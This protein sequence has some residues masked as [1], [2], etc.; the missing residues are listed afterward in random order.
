M[1]TTTPADIRAMFERKQALLKFRYA[2][3]NKAMSAVNRID[4]DIR[5]REAEIR[6][7]KEKLVDL[8][9]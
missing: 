2:E 9:G 4:R 3:R 6:D 5:K 7:L 1:A 8:Q